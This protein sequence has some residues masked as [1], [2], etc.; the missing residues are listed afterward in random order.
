M[1]DGAVPVRPLLLLTNDDGVDAPLLAGLA[2][3]LAVDHD[4]LIVAPERQRS[5]ASHAITLHKPLRAREVGPGRWSLSGTPVDCIYVGVLRLAPRR[6]AL[7]VSGPNDG[8]NL[9]TDVFYSGTVAGAREGALRGLP[10][11]AL[12]ISPRAT[13]VPDALA[14]AAAL[15]RSAVGALPGGELLNV[16]I[17]GHGERRYAWTTLGRRNYADDVTERAD[18]WGRPYYWIGGGSTGHDDVPGSDCNAVADGLASVTPI[19]L[20]VD[21]RARVAAPPFSVVGYDATSV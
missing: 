8:F 21:H 18:P 13:H 14:F 12:S 9:G 19:R 7:V 10:G 1:S 2:A 16:N 20:D 17:P 15:V 5:A 11:V 3:A 6:P 4:V